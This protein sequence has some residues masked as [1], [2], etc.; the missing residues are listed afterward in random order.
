MTSIL[1]LAEVDADLRC[2]LASLGASITESLPLSSTVEPRAFRLTTAAG[3]RMKLRVLRTSRHAEVEAYVLESFAGDSFPRL[4]GRAGRWILCTW[5]EGLPAAAAC[6]VELVRRCAAVQSRLHGLRPPPASASAWRTPEERLKRVATHLERLCGAGKL[7]ASASARA[8]R[9]AREYAPGTAVTGLGHGDLCAEN[10]VVRADG[11]P[12][13]VDNETIAVMPLDHDLARTWYRWPM[14]SNHWQ[15]YLDE[16]ASF[17]DPAP[18][19]S[20]FPFWAVAV[21]AAS[22]VLRLERPGWSPHQPL[23]RLRGILRSAEDGCS[24]E[25]LALA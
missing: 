3:R 12:V 14:P 5:V 10:I 17:R 23:D 2:L 1:P 4:C 19:L 8:L 25:Q 7:A 20:H 18:F 24:P 21:L 22:A 11:A 6:T 16:Y 9:I 15:A 13:V